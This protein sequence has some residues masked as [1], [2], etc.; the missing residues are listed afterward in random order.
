MK[1]AVMGAGA[2][3]GYFGGRLAAAGHNV[4]LI[5]RGAHLAAI[6]ADGLRILSP[7]GD[8]HLPGIGATDDPAA[9]GPVD[10]ILF[11]VKTYDLEHAAEAIR[12]ML[13]PETFVVT[14]QNGVSAPERL[15]AAIGPE[16]VVPGVARIPGEVAQPGVIRHTAPL[17]ILIFGEAAGGVSARCERLAAALNDAGMTPKAH[18]A[19][20][21]ELWSKMI[22][23]A[24]LASLTALTRLDLG[25][26]RET[27][28]TRQ[29]MT[30]A[31][32]EAAAVG[33]AEVPDLPDDLIAANWAFLDG[34][35]REMHASMLDDL[36]NG[37]RLEVDHLSGD[38]VRLGRRHGIPTPIHF[39]FWA[40]LKPYADG[41]VAA[42]RP[43]G[44]PVP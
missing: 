24:M 8:L 5:A 14:C 11:M 16:R 3:G 13:G 23:Q 2:L 26:L 17:D 7:R 30:D 6:R 38:I 12:P 34:L 4:T 27:L 33:R 42:P 44:A 9:V 25:P 37:K 19:I 35:P 28:Q 32:E 43:D 31:M 20:R 36:R 41:P 15:A 18:P 1:I 29:L 21:H 40:A 10:A 39:T 22:S